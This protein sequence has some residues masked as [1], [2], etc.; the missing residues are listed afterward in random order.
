MM[1]CVLLCTNMKVFAFI[2][3]LKIL[4]LGTFNIEWVTSQMDTVIKI[5]DGVGSPW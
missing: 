3:M 2:Q 5:G 1:G 4:V